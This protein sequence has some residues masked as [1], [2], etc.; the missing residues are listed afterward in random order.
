VGYEICDCGSCGALRGACS[1]DKAV[2][3]TIEKWQQDELCH[4]MV[5]PFF[6][7]KWRTHCVSVHR[8]LGKHSKCSYK[9]ASLDVEVSNIAGLGV[10]LLRVSISLIHIIP[11]S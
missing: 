8:I 7:R 1:E 2:A 3:V 11:T 4:L 10:I 5:L 9:F 6:E